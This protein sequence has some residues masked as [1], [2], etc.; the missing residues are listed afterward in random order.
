M[1]DLNNFLSENEVDTSQPHVT[2]EGEG[3]DDKAYVLA[4]EK[5]KRERRR[6][7]EGAQKILDEAFRLKREGDV[8]KNARIAGA[9][10]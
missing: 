2:K 9:Y 4:M 8:A 7:F 3:A 5:Y 6:D 1:K 10:I